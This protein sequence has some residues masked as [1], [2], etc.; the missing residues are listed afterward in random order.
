MATSRTRVS[1]RRSRRRTAAKLSLVAIALLAAMG[2]TGTA[3][4]Y[5]LY[6]SY[7]SQLPDAATLAAME[8]PLDTHVYD[9]AGSLIATFY[10]DQRHVNIPLDQMSRWVRLA[11][12]DVEDRR[13]YS[14][15]SWDLQRIVKAGYT[16]LRGGAQQ[17][18]S[19]ITQ[20]LAKISFLGFGSRTLE[21]KAKQVILGIE[22]ENNFSKD[23]ILAMYLNRIEYGNHSVGIETAAETYF[24]KSAHDLDLAEAAMLAGLPN[25]PTYLYPLNHAP[26]L[27]ENPA[28]K[29]RQKVVL[30]A[31]VNNGD[32]TQA[33]AVAAAAEPLT[34]HYVGDNEPDPTDFTV[35]V[36]TWLQDHFGGAFLNPGGWEVHTTLDP[37]RQAIAEQ[38]VRSGVAAVSSKNARDGALVSMDPRSGEIVAMVGAADPN[39]KDIG[40]FNASTAELQPGSTI[41]LFTYT[42]AI[43]TRKLTMHS[44]IVDQRT[45]FKIP[46]SPDYVP[47]NYDL[48]YHGTC[49]L[50]QCL[51]NSF[52]IPAVK[53][54]QKV[55]IPYITDLEIAMGLTSLAIP[56]NRPAPYQWSATLGGLTHGVAPLELA[57]GAATLADLG[58][59]HDPVPVKS[60]VD[61]NHGNATV[62]VDDPATSGV[63]VVPANVAFIMDEMTSNDNNRV[64]EFGANGDLTLKDRRVS[65]KTGTTQ[66]FISN[67]TVGF[68]PD[69]VSVVWVGNARQSCLKPE[70]RAKLLQLMRTK[71]IYSGQSIDDP[72]TPG[73]LA[74]YGL[75][76]IN[77]SCG[78]LVGSTG[79]TGAA[80]IWNAYMRQALGPPVPWFTKPPDL[81]QDGTGDNAYYYLPG[82]AAGYDESHCYH[83][84]KAPAAA[85]PCVYV[86]SSH[87]VAPPAPAATPA[88]AAPTA[89]PPGYQPPPTH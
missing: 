66:D 60:I 43:A 29:D 69:L 84:G 28:A 33:Q 41:K 48:R 8:P 9:A 61:R 57:D 49:Q 54:E 24:H 83:Y 71:V 39:N 22:I 67:W 36:R 76:P 79:I 46:G 23:Q 30:Q 74:A 51:G 56:D 18:A 82:T 44:P 45:A 53:V 38:A 17:G 58:I 64:R 25:S 26:G 86:G 10:G 50:M 72:F 85:D 68:T 14:E 20:Q 75:Q 1:R 19:T 59:H 4:A 77:S 40:Q 11:T 70:D 37:R 78:H 34:F 62:F 6:Q 65:A 13:F 80:P 32:I 63:R 7:R 89:A 87:Y 55:G 27:E 15:G 3:V 16:N 21:Y 31:M 2:M 35:Y 88:P 5:G 47:T 42:A 73:E 12:V 81:L 52:N